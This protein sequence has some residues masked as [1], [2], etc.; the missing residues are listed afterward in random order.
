MS[1]DRA[2]DALAT[3][4]TKLHFPESI[5]PSRNS[6]QTIVTDVT[7]LKGT[8]F[9]PFPGTDAVAK[10]YNN[11]M[12]Y[13]TCVKDFYESNLVVAVFK[14]QLYFRCHRAILAGTELLVWGG[15]KKAHL[16]DF[17][18]W[19]KEKLTFVCQVCDFESENMQTLI[20]HC[21]T[22]H[23]MRDVP[24]T[25][26]KCPYC[27]HVAT[28]RTNL[29]KHIIGHG[30]NL[31]KAQLPTEKCIKK[32]K[33]AKIN[34]KNNKIQNN[35]PTMVKETMTPTIDITEM[36]NIPLAAAESI[37][38]APESHN[39]KCKFCKKTFNRIKQL[40][41][42]MG[43]KHK[44]NKYEYQQLPNNDDK[45]SSDN[46]PIHLSPWKRRR[47]RQKRMGIVD[48]K[49]SYCDKT[50]FTYQTRSRHIRSVHLGI[51]YFCSVCKKGFCR[52]DQSINHIRR[53]HPN[54]SKVYMIIKEKDT[55]ISQIL[56]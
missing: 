56:V 4:N 8:N 16:G 47:Q 19:G 29:R 53:K 45:Q 44:I 46:K 48:F 15:N 42:H 32:K 2:A 31:F 35:T 27:P 9:G 52:K 20:I 11:W 55:I 43:S 50:F 36:K 6:D 37:T 13:V 21:N 28:L 51:K 18:R 17:S 33:T 40:Y 24:R 14:K 26:C 49:C 7:I 25:N 38:G 10:D 41:G 5:I 23:Q 30:I 1:A 3:T 54:K 22:V 12:E 39:Y 34:E